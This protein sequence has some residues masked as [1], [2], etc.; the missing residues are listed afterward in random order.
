MI[1]EYLRELFSIDGEP[2]TWREWLY[3]TIGAAFFFAFCVFMSCLQYVIE[4]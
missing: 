3:G 2:I 4:G 1:F